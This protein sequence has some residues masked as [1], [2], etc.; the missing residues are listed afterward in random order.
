MMKIS[1][2]IK[3]IALGLIPVVLFL[4]L[5]LAYLIPVVKESLYQEKEVQT[6]EMVATAIGILQHFYNEEQ[7]GR[8]TRREAQSRASDVIAAM[9]FG[10]D[11]QD[12]F[13]INDFHP[14]IIMHPFRPDLEGEDVSR[15]SDPEGVYLF[16]EFVDVVQKQGSGY[17][18]YHWQYYDDRDRVEP[19]LS[20]VQGF[21][22]WQW[23]VGT[24]VY[25]NDVDQIAG[26]TRNTSL[27]WTLLIL[28]LT[29]TVVFF[30]LMNIL[31]PLLGAVAF[32]NDIADGGS[33]DQSFKVK[34]ND[35]IR[36][37]AMS[38]NK[39]VSHLKGKIQEANIETEKA[40]EATEKA[41]IATEEAIEAKRLADEATIKGRQDAALQLTDVVNII[42]S[43]AEELSAQ[44]EQSDRTAE[45]QA[46]QCEITATSME[47]MNSTVLEV[48]KN[49]SYAAENASKVN[50]IAHQSE[51]TMLESIDAI[52]NVNDKAATMKVSLDD[53]GKQAQQITKIINTIDDI[54]D[55]TNLLAL[56]A[57]I[58]AAR[59]G[60]AGRGFAVV[61]DEV[62]KLA[63]KT[64]AAT[65][66]VET[67][68]STIQESVSTNIKDMDNAGEAVQTTN[69]KIKLLGDE[70][71]KI[72]KMAQDTSDQV[73]AIATAAEEQS[74]ASE[75]VTQSITIINTS[76]REA[77]DVTKQS[78]QALVELSSQAQELQSIIEELKK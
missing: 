20:F 56:N 49:A 53:L 47:E 76:A 50:S 63:E 78:A 41:R 45:E 17:V 67:S 71:A 66:E 57:A 54:A 7:Q 38:L 4:A 75:E 3:M 65:K 77:S 73:T 34:N 8:L 35:E 16:S 48:A 19:K 68:I 29:S 30:I 28:A 5:I 58:E 2:K 31:R 39:M 36:T 69:E 32:A 42:S 23:I 6:K 12:Y 46:K 60:E 15:I 40:N 74:T 26:A 1:I 11:R 24:G 59:A 21:E 55:Q 10:R 25:I 37:L 52:N 27:L 62:R 13:W 72:V 18:I 51:V 22:P 33:L 61:A 9:T 70:L 43:A 44:V 64:Q 14:R